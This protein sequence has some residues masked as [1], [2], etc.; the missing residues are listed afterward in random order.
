MR[1][2]NE[3]RRLIVNIHGMPG[4]SD[5]EKGR[6]VQELMTSN[7]LLSRKQKQL[8]QNNEAA[9]LLKNN[10]TTKKY[11]SDDCCDG[12]SSIGNNLASASSDSISTAVNRDNPNSDIHV[13]NSNINS[14]NNSHP[15]GSGCKSGGC[16]NNTEH[17]IGRTATGVVQ[18]FY[19]KERN[20]LGCQHYM[21]G[22][23]IQAPCCKN[24]YTCR[25]CHDAN[26]LHN[27]DRYAISVIQC[28]YC[29][30]VQG[31]NKVCESKSCSKVLGSYYCSTCKL[32]DDD[33]SKNIYH[34]DKCG[35][36][37]V[38]QGDDY[39]HCDRCNVCMSKHLKGKHK[40]IERNLESN[41][42]ICHEYMFTSTHTII[43]MRCGHCIHHSCYKNYIKKSYKCPICV[44]SLG[45]MSEYFKKI[46]T[47]MKVQKMPEEYGQSTTDIVCNDCLVRGTVPYH[48]QFHKCT[49]E[50]CGS[51]NTTIIKVSHPA[52]I[53][54]LALPAH[55][56]QNISTT[57]TSSSSASNPISSST[58][59][60][61][62]TSYGLL[63]RSLQQID[64]RTFQQIDNGRDGDESN[65][66]FGSSSDDN[67]SSLVINNNSNT[68]NN[69]NTI[70]NVNIDVEQPL[71]RSTR[72]RSIQVVS[73][74]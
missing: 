37:R 21:R 23:R 69:G 50:D 39:F 26:E 6:K 11:K 15:C 72:H 10:S 1:D 8:Q 64:A 16:S 19:S 57:I 24:W 22:A 61:S 58:E 7:W 2:E 51:Y 55:L 42:P 54:N 14:N 48:F 74:E 18:S 44:K 46:D 36:C 20:I 65:S 40:C 32:W 49:K 67:N 66:D 47:M 45:D 68:I 28:M 34:C 29:G 27:I 73:D 59:S 17:G 25:L 62:R 38:G 60:T 4:L 43:F 70:S 5:E 3:L 12:D 33:V 31:P 13:I 30:L 52:S 41:C 71:R 63:E 56:Q 9:D 53:T 35:M